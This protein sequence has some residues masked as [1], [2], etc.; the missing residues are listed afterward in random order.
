MGKRVIIVGAG[1]VG[2]TLAKELA[3]KGIDVIVHDSKRHVSDGAAK[4]SGIFSITGLGRIGI[5]PESAIVNR[6]DGAV[7]HAGHER[8]KVKSGETKAYVVD[9]GKLAEVCKKLA[10]GADAKIMLGSKLG[11]IEL[12]RLASNRD[13]I[14]VGADGAV[15]IVASTFGFPEIKEYVLTYKAEYANADID[16]PAMAGLFFSNE[17]AYRFFGWSCP[18]SK[19]RIEIG[20]GISDRAKINSTAAFSKFEHSGMIDNMIKGAEKLS[21]YASI[22]PLSARSSTVKGNVMLVGDAAGQVKATTGGGIIFGC[23]CAKI[24]ADA[25]RSNI[26][27][28]KPLDAYEKEWRRRYSLD[29]KMHDFL[30]NYYS[31][32][33]VSNFEVFL[34][35][36]K[37]LGA[38]G[39]FSKY[40]DMDRP[41]LML[42]RFFLR[43][44]AK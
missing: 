43:G 6:L 22:I 14:I 13:N 24:L 28:G 39:F 15:S 34:K 2:L 26:E 12:E 10:E 31:N 16:D 25:V 17:I 36:S 35:I 27:G 5:N 44:L 11:K 20:I 1:V 23:S 21:G 33:K 4:A 37:M 3:L 8:L 9:R 7:L 40:G 18:Y 41:S 19:D 32:L 38:E 30:H 29:L 42:K